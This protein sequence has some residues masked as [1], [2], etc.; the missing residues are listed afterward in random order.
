MEIKDGVWA[1]GRRHGQRLQVLA[2]NPNLSAHMIGMLHKVSQTEAQTEWERMTERLEETKTIA[3]LKTPGTKGAEAAL[4]GQRLCKL[5]LFFKNFV[6]SCMQGPLWRNFNILTFKK[7]TGWGRKLSFSELLRSHWLRKDP[8]KRS[9]NDDYSRL[10]AFQW[11][12]TEKGPDLA[13]GRSQ[14]S[15]LRKVAWWDV[16]II[17]SNT[18]VSISKICS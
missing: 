13:I 7:I 15:L 18:E 2:A 8:I 9:R 11:Q 12:F 1:S 17:N 14:R 5:T 4:G 3:W 6:T 16:I 10:T